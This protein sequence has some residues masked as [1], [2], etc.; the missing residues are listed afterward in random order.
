MFLESPHDDG[1]A[2]RNSPQLVEGIC[3]KL[4]H[5]S[6]ESLDASVIVWIGLS[7]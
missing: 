4:S 6:F 1:L 7:I 5:I 2:R 3:T